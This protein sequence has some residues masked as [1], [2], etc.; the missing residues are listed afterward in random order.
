MTVPD[1]RVFIA[2]D[3]AAGGSGDFF[4]LNDPVKGVLSGGTV[5]SVYPLAGDILEDV[6]GDVRRLSV[7]RGR[8]RQLERFNA[9]AASV[10]LDNMGRKYDPAAGTAITP[11]GPSMRPRKQVTIEANEQRIFTGVVDDWDLKYS[12]DGDHVTSVS[13]VDGFVELAG[14]VIGEHVPTQQLSG[15]RINAILDRPE[16]VWSSGRDI[17]PGEATLGTAIVSGDGQP[18]N[19][20]AYLQEV[21]SAEPGA[22]FVAANGVLTFRDRD[23][24]QTAKFVEFR[25]DGN[26]IPFT[27]IDVSYGSEELRNRATVSIATGGTVTSEVASSVTAYGPIDFTVSDS[28]LADVT[29]AQTF[30]DWVVNTFAEPQLR[31]D[32]VEVN[33][34]G[35]DVFQ[36]N[37]VIGLELGD[38]VLVRFTPSGIGDPIESYVAIDA[39]E[40]TVEPLRHM[41]RFDLSSIVAGFVL[42]ST[43]FGV[44]DESRLGF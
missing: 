5:T 14:Q 28:L 38:V 1:T 43:V 19:L 3:L 15:A 36:Q 12:L 26:G 30:A 27:N 44:L 40:H 29:Q 33:L 18:E 10:E 23:D 39:I 21:E 7:R 11:Y 13:A 31:I 17:A 32:Q 35:L 34:S 4:T 9:G 37:Q 25:D 42:D 20:L 2:F 41:V 24:L 6:T 16:V 8:S 22:L